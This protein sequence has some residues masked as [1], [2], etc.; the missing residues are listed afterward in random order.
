VATN[1]TGAERLTPP[2]A[3]DGDEADGTAEK[4]ARPRKSKACRAGPP[5]EQHRDAW[6]DR[7]IAAAFRFLVS[8][9]RRFGVDERGER[10]S[11]QLPRVMP[12]TAHLPDEI[13]AVLLRHTQVADQHVWARRRKRLDRFADAA[14]RGDDGADLFQHHDQDSPGVGFVVKR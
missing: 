13:E 4:S 11:G 8:C 9:V 2:F 6:R 1:G 5:A 10:D 12:M 14:R 3:L 7:K